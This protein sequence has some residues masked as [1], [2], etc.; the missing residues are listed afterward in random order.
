MESDLSTD[1]SSFFINIES[2][3]NLRQFGANNAKRDNTPSR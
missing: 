3:W 2:I 1:Y